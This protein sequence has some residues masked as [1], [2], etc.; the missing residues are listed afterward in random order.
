MGQKGFVLL[1]LSF[2]FMAL[3]LSLIVHLLTSYLQISQ[4]YFVPCAKVA[5]LV[6]FAQ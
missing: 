3:T 2:E 6:L 4:F 5:V 1:P